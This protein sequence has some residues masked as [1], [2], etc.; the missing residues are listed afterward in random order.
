M[1]LEVYEKVNGLGFWAKDWALDPEVGEGSG[2]PTDPQ[3]TS[4]SAQLSNE[5]P[6]TVLSSSQLKKTHK[7][8]KAKRTTKISQ[9]SGPI[10][11]FADET[12]YKEWEDRM[13][14]AVTTASSLEADQDSGNINR[15]QSMATL[16]E[17]FPQGTGSGSGPRCQVTI[18]GG[19]T[20]AQTRFVAAS[21]QSNDLP[22]SRVNTLG[23]GEDNTKLKELM[24]LYTK[25]SYCDQH[26]MVALL[27]KTD[28]SEG[29]HQ[30]VDFLNASHIRF[31]L[32]ENPTIYDSHI[33]QFWQTAT[34]NTLDNGEQEITATVDGHVKTVTIAS[35]RKYL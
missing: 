14:R 21:K 3:Y 24:E 8:R 6:I 10:H 4:T 15:T 2:Q 18:L 16:N 32:S 19:G 26:N 35:V 22:L 20:E 29:F 28:G 23:S 34:V 12:V 27:E 13:E 5:E 33:K 17:P 9:S 30:I 1:V 11:L 25:L 31:A 7:P